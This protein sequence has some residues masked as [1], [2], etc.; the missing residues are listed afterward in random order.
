MARFP[1]TASKV[2][3]G[4]SLPVEKICMRWK[5]LLGSPMPTLLERRCLHVYLNVVPSACFAVRNSIRWRAGGDGGSRFWFGSDE[6]DS[7]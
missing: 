6:R 2:T 1:D 3:T 7:V 4:P 5:K